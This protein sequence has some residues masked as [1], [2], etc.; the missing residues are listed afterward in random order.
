MP[1]KTN[2]SPMVEA[3]VSWR[4]HSLKSRHSGSRIQIA[5]ACATGASCRA[6]SGPRLELIVKKRRAHLLGQQFAPCSTLHGRQTDDAAPGTAEVATVRRLFN[7]EQRQFRGEVR[8]VT[9]Y[10]VKQWVPAAIAHGEAH[11]VEE[12]HRAIGFGKKIAATARKRRIQDRMERS[13]PRAM[14]PASLIDDRG[15]RTE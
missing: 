9:Q 1:V 13:R 10:V 12:L 15:A 2:P 6:C 3:S 7:V 11:G 8:I 4:A 5:S 14:N